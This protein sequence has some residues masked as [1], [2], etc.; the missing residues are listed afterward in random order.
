MHRHVRE[1]TRAHAPHARRLRLFECAL[2]VSPLE[3]CLV[4]E[5]EGGGRGRRAS[6]RRGW[7][8]E[9]NNPTGV[10]PTSANVSTPTRSRSFASLEKG[11]RK[12]EARGEGKEEAGFEVQIR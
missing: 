8:E 7:R 4:T 6:A 1:G 2:A 11:E 3:N 12:K 9:G 10:F 5:G